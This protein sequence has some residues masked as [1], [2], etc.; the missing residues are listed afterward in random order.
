MKRTI[1]FAFLSLA[2]CCASTAY[3]QLPGDFD[4]NGV[5][6]GLDFLLWQRKHPSVFFILADWEANYGN[7]APL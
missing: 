7:V 5:V 3:A 4:S 1:A 6:D 2:L